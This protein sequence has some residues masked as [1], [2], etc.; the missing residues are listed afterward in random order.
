VC[1]SSKFASDIADFCLRDLFVYF[2][3]QLRSSN[4]MD[5]ERI[6]TF[7]EIMKGKI[8]SPYHCR[9]VTEILTHCLE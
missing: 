5:G 7:N 8:I 4:S 1:L 2:K 6:Q 3:G 9:T